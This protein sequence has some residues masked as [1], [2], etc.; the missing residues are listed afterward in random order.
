[1]KVGWD[2][3]VDE[4]VQINAGLHLELGKERARNRV[5]LL[6]VEELET[7]LPSVEGEPDAG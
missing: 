7:A 1:M 5:L 6:R 2:Q 4:L 3:V